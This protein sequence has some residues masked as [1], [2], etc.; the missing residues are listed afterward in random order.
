MYTRW[1]KFGLLTITGIVCLVLVASAAAQKIVPEY[2]EQLKYRHVGPVG[3]RFIAVAGIAGD[4]MVYYAGAASGGLWKTVDGGL[5]W[6]PVFDDQPV[7]SIGAVTVAASDPEIVWVGTGETFIRSNVSIGNGVWKTTDGGETWRHAGLEGTGRI[8]R[9]IV[10][11]TNPDVVYVAALGDAYLPRPERGIY[12]TRDGGDSWERVLAVND[13]TGASDLVMHPNNPRILFAGMWQLDIKTWGRES[14]GPGSGI[15]VTRDGGDT[16][17]AL[18]GNGL[19]GRPVGK[20]GLAMTPADPQRIY[21]LIETGDGVPWH[22]QETDSGELWRSDNGGRHWKLMTHNRDLGGRQPYY[23]RCAVSPDDPDE[24]YFLAAAYS[25]TKDGGRTSKALT[26]SARPT[27]DHHDIWI[28]PTEADRMI[29]AGDGGLAITQNRGTSWFRVQLPVA[30]LYHVTVDN[31]VPYYV[32]TNRQDGPSMRGPSRS[33]NG[34]FL[35]S[36]IPRGMWHSVGGGESGF[37]TPDPVDPDIIWSSASGAGARGGIVVRYNERT[38]QYRQVEVWP[39]VTA[40]WPAENLKYRFQWTFPLLISPHDPNTIYVTSQHVHRTTTGGQRWDVISP[41]LTTNDKSR[42][43]NSGG[44]TPDNIGVEYFS[45]IYAFDE[46]PVQQGVLWAGTNDGLVQVSRDG[47]AI[48]T[49]VTDNIPNLAPLGTVRNI[50]A[51]RWEA[52]RAYITVDFHE[53]GD[54]KPYVYKTDDFGANWRNITSGISVSPLSFARHILE[55]PVRPGL[56]YL[57]T[58][59]AMYVSFN[60]GEKWQPFMTNMPAAPMYWIAVQEHFNDLVVGTY[61]RGIWI[62]DDI[63]PLQQLTADVMSASAHLFKPRPAYR[64]QPITE[65]MKMFDD[66]S[67]GDDPPAAASINYWLREATEDS[68]NI[69][70]VNAFG[71]T[72]RTLPGTGK[73][74]IN[75]VWWNLWGE[76]TTQI[77]LRTK[78]QFADWVELDEDRTRNALVGRITRLAP[79]GTYTVLLEVAGQEYMQT[80]VVHKDPHSEGTESDIDAQTAMV[81]S[82]Q[83]DMNTAAD[84]VNRIELVRRQIYDLKSLLKDRTDAGEIVSA[85]DLLDGKLIG[86]EEKRIQMKRSGT[87]QD[88]IRWPSMLVS[89]IGYLAGAVAVADFSPTDQHQ[90]V[91]QI[92]K[93]RLQQYL[94]DLEHILQADIPAFN[95]LLQDNGLTSVI[96]TM[97]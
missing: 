62:M 4:P 12:R 6:T 3:N 96:T 58:E 86:V 17:K 94:E 72:V 73:A 25:V 61:G 44:L 52:G 31:N 16:W 27:W 8:G 14:G 48:W 76:P 81:R 32:Y 83:E 11:P 79:P 66:Q 46:S 2:Y 43:R 92:L 77:K 78:P 39:E 89:R 38:R 75:R 30:Q 18:E 24:V 36:G 55:D 60:D 50:D 7:H 45:V 42:Q 34:R 71:N 70:I 68:V 80:L 40:G 82:L 90:E 13:S 23:T 57:G 9:V 63:T 69:R 26:G 15:F 65:P 19:P 35:N 28:D 21:A 41:D 91:H 29:V 49:N 33:R 88:V 51:S 56:L 87:G 20:I 97:Q 22:G 64:F 1:T 95:M 5:T 74:G 53:V 85:V 93:K 54:F 84:L 47:G 67:D 10:H 59:N 37:A